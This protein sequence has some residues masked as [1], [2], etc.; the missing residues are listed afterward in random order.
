MN[1][2]LINTLAQS[3]NTEKESIKKEIENIRKYCRSLEGMQWD[4]IVAFCA[5]SALVN[6]DFGDIFAD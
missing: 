4:E 5:T 6:P 1:E 3:N 2:L